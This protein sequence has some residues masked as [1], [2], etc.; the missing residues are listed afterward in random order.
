MTLN[1]RIET[2]EPSLQALIED[3]DPALRD[4][5]GKIDEAMRYE[6]FEILPNDKL[7]F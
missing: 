5:A 6:A 4:L 3:F 7:S 1:Q 2:H